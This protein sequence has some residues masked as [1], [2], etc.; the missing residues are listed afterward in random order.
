MDKNRKRFGFSLKIENI[1][2]T[3]STS[4]LERPKQSAIHVACQLMLEWSTRFFWNSIW[5]FVCA[6]Y[7]SNQGEIFL[8]HPETG[9][10]EP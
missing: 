4:K 7:V 2:I 10:V 6:C 8:S 5:I 9:N 3:E 1:Q